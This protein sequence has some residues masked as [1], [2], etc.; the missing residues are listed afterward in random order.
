MNNCNRNRIYN[1]LKKMDLLDN[2]EFIATVSSIRDINEL[3]YNKYN[4]EQSDIFLEIKDDFTSVNDKVS[5]K[6]NVEIAEKILSYVDNFGIENNKQKA[7]ELNDSNKTRKFY[8]EKDSIFY[9]SKNE[10][11]LRDDDYQ[12]IIENLI[13][14]FTKYGEKKGQ[15]IFFSELGKHLQDSNIEKRKID[16]GIINLINKNKE[17]IINEAKMLYDKA[18]SQKSEIHIFGQHDAEVNIWN[19]IPNLLTQFFSFIP[20][21]DKQKIIGLNSFYKKGAVLKHIYTIFNSN[22][23]KGDISNVKEKDIDSDFLNYF[24][25]QVRIILKEKIKDKQF[26]HQLS[27][28]LSKSKIDFFYYIR[29]KKISN[30]I[31]EIDTI[32]TNFFIRN[33]KNSIIDSKNK[34]IFHSKVRYSNFKK[35]INKSQKDEIRTNVETLIKNINKTDDLYNF[36]RNV[37]NQNSIAPLLVLEG[38]ELRENNFSDFFRYVELTDNQKIFKK[39]VIDIANNFLSHGHNATN[40]K[41][42]IDRKLNES[43][44]EF[45]VDLNRHATMDNVPTIKEKGKKINEFGS[46]NQVTKVFNNKNK[47]KQNIDDLAKDDKYSNMIL[48]KIKDDIVIKGKHGLQNAFNLTQSSLFVDNKNEGTLI[49]KSNKDISSI[50]QV[51]SNFYKNTPLLNTQGKKLT[52]QFNIQDKNSIYDFILVN[53]LIGVFGDKGRSIFITVPFINF[54]KNFSENFRVNEE[55]LQNNNLRN[56]LSYLTRYYYSEVVYPEYQRI[57]EHNP[58]TNMVKFNKGGLFFI[59]APFLNVKKINNDEKTIQERIVEAKNLNTNEKP[60]KLGKIESDILNTIYDRFYTYLKNNA[61]NEYGL[62]NQIEEKIHKVYMNALLFGDPADY[63]YVKEGKLDYFKTVL[64]VTKRN[65]AAITTKENVALEEPFNVIIAEDVVRPFDNLQDI[66]NTYFKIEN[67]YKKKLKRDTLI[68]KYLNTTNKEDYDNLQAQIKNEFPELSPFLEGEMT[69]GQSWITAETA[70][71]YHYAKGRFSEKEYNTLRKK[72]KTFNKQLSN[73]EPV[74][75]TFN[76]KEKMIFDV[77]KYIIVDKNFYLKTSLRVLLPYSK[78]EKEQLKFLLSQK[79]NTILTVKS[80]VKRGAPVSRVSL[81]LGKNMF[82]IPQNKDVLD[83]NTIILRPEAL[84]EQIDKS[85]NWTKENE[86]KLTPQ[87]SR[88]F[89]GFNDKSDYFNRFYNFTISLLN[90]QKELDIQDLTNILNENF[91]IDNYV[92]Y[93]ANDINLDITAE[94]QIPKIRGHLKKK[95][96]N[97]K[98]PGGHYTLMSGENINGF[99]KN[100]NII[101]TKHYDGNF[102]TRTVDGVTIFDVIMPFSFKDKNGNKIK[103]IENNKINESIVEE[104]ENGY[105][106]KDVLPNE[107]YNIIFFR[108]PLSGPPS[109][110]IGRIVGFNNFEEGFI[111]SPEAMTIEGADYD[112]DSIYNYNYNTV[113][114][115]IE[116]VF[117]IK[118]E[119]TKDK[120]FDIM[121]DLFTGKEMQKNMMNPINVNTIQYTSDFFAKIIPSNIH[122]NTT[123]LIDQKISADAMGRFNPYMSV[124]QE[125]LTI[126][127]TNNTVPYQNMKMVFGDNKQTETIEVLLQKKHKEIE[128]DLSEFQN[129]ILDNSKLGKL[130][131]LNVTEQTATYAAAMILSGF[132]KSIVTYEGEKHIINTFA[133]FYLNPYINKLLNG[134]VKHKENKHADLSKLKIT[135]DTL[136]SYI[137]DKNKKISKLEKEYLYRFYEKIHLLNQKLSLLSSFSQIGSTFLKGNKESFFN[138]ISLFDKMKKNNLLSYIFKE[139]INKEDYDMLVEQNNHKEFIWLDIMERAYKPTTPFNYFIFKSIEEYYNSLKK[140][141]VNLYPK[142]VKSLMDSYNLIKNENNRR[143][144]VKNFDVYFYN[145][146]ELVESII[147]KDKAIVENYINRYNKN[148]SKY[149]I[150]NIIDYLQKSHQ[151]IYDGLSNNDSNAFL[152]NIHKTF[153]LDKKIKKT[154]NNNE[155]IHFPYT[156]AFIDNRSESIEQIQELLRSDKKIIDEVT[157]EFIITEKNLIKLLINYSLIASGDVSYK[158][159]RRYVPDYYL[160]EINYIDKANELIKYEENSNNIDLKR[161]ERQYFI[162]NKNL[163]EN[164]TGKN[165]YKR[166]NKNDKFLITKEYDFI[167]IV[168]DADNMFKEQKPFIKFNGH[169]YQL[170]NN[171]YRLLMSNE[172]YYIQEDYLLNWSNDNFIYDNKLI[173]FSFENLSADN[174]NALYSKESKINKNKYNLIYT[175]GLFNFDNNFKKSVLDYKLDKNVDNVLDNNLLEYITRFFDLKYKDSLE[176]NQYENYMKK[177]FYMITNK[178]V[179]EKFIKDNNFE[180]NLI[181]NMLYN[182]Q[183]LIN[184]DSIIDESAEG[185]SKLNEIKEEIDEYADIKKEAKEEYENRKINCIK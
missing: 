74:T 173:N 176:K 84:G 8:E 135:D 97:P 152:G 139:E 136:L 94:N 22:K 179:F 120:Y 91:S 36:F 57:L 71:N 54:R 111:S 7:Q 56:R 129:A 17:L 66:A 162:K 27:D 50:I 143:I 166:K 15:D 147:D 127:K 78:A 48:M 107:A 77:F 106:M 159:I 87:V 79:E 99:I 151:L 109:V 118:R 52:Y 45:I 26:L 100:E 133:L 42:I 65:V 68:V 105:F 92:R 80:A 154:N 11:G 158:T 46:H 19:T 169:V 76:G 153:L 182:E 14:N 4:L 132:N 161:F 34:I 3:V 144:F 131:N 2:N 119:S 148:N 185:F 126:Y 171:Q 53:R 95:I 93:D 101:Y 41:P 51:Y 98:V 47:L 164:E 39:F 69:D 165:M 130:T 117:I 140:L 150:K 16:I 60:E 156:E 37:N 35:K 83:D 122:D 128:E 75:V 90:E 58:E 63:A 13:Y 72:V 21:L 43:Y 1:F 123:L 88:L 64:E 145:N 181:I 18:Y 142:T 110:Q 61:Q 73:E 31:G 24:N 81:F 146:K 85:G 121:Y 12:V 9:G 157:K 172:S 167:P 59:E 20:N 114:D 44:L 30:N 28:F 5:Y 141:R 38:L 23:F 180:E 103:L 170:I 33:K 104:K 112:D 40:Y 115:D 160:R 102:S 108:M 124:F 89:S 137:I 25:N 55:N 184:K 174:L 183:L 116:K 178:N 96:L 32:Q 6:I 134:V 113:Y 155:I 125:I 82:R 177:I 163:L 175:I 67:N 138:L 29:N 10:S 168:F 86:N 62:I 70:L 149:E 49:K